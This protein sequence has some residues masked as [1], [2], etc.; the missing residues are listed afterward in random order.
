MLTD[1]KIAAIKPPLEGQQEHP[2]QKV[3][4]LRLR[5]GAGGK[6]TW[7][8]RRRVGDKVINRKLGNYPAMGLSAARKA[9]ESVLE[10]LETHGSIEGLDRTY[11]DLARHWL[12]NDA[13]ENN[14]SWRDQW[15]R[16][17]MYVLP[18]WETRRIAEIQRRDIRDL[19]SGIE[20]EVLPNRVLSV[21]RRIFNYALE[22]DW[23]AASPAQGVKA[24]KAE[25]PRDRT[26]SMSE[27]VALWD[28]VALLGYP[29]GYFVRM[30]LLTAQRRNEVA[31]MKWADLDLEAGTWTVRSEDTKSDRANLVP[32]SA[33]ALTILDTVPKIGPHVFTSDGETH[34]SGFSKS[35]AS[36]DK[37][38]SAKGNAIEPWTLHDLRRTAATHMVRLGTPELVVSR[39]LNHVAAGV[40]G[41]VYALH[42]Y[43][44]EKR[45]ALDAWGTDLL[46]AVNGT[47]GENVVA[48]G[49]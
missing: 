42:T 32:L 7:T 40:T 47:G 13:K 22:Q 34:F 18:A 9:A 3:T 36:L 45:H 17:E 24:P 27:V 10:A 5:V 38:M 12:A 8:L 11:G 15:R 19:L 26:L 46:R 39:I 49:A 41:K 23:L 29:F 14:S 43:A 35:K 30:L 4:G 21:V 25:T 33:P 20:G 37:F 28:A 48:I 6:K 2:D 31:S 16:L 1:A 44:P